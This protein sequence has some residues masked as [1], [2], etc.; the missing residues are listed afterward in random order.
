MK[1][2]LIIIVT[3]LM[4]LIIG[5]V[6]LFNITRA[7]INVTNRNSIVF[8]A[9]YMTLNNQFFEV[10]NNEI[11]NVVEANGDIL[12]TMNPELSLDK[13]IEQINYLIDKNVDVLIIN[14]VDYEGLKD[15]LK[16]AKDNGIYVITVDTNID[17][18]KEYI[19]Y[20]VVSDNYLAGEL[21]ALDMMKEIDKANIF[22][23]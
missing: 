3:S 9:S 21:C 16:R 17:D 12:V 5:A 10:I 23:N 19:D 13:Q 8:G 1:K 2:R 20:T 15:V 18:G 11:K 4:L 14:P 6:Q 7:N 22:I